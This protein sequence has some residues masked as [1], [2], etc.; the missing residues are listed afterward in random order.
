MIMRASHLMLPDRLRGIAAAV[1]ASILIAAAS[2]VVAQPNKA[3]H[4]AAR[5]EG[6][7]GA[8]QNNALQGFSQNKNQPVQIEAASLEVRDKEKKATF[9]GNVKVVQGDTT[10]RCKA[11]VVFYDSARTRRASQ[12]GTQTMKA[13]AP[14]PG[15]SS[16]IS[17]LEATGG[18]TVTQ[19]DQVA[20]GERADFDMK[21]NTV[22]LQGEGGGQPGPEPDAR[23]PAGR[24]SHDRGVLEVEGSGPVSVLIDNNG[25]GRRTGQQGRQRRK[26]RQGWIGRTGRLRRDGPKFGPQRQKFNK[27]RHKPG[28]R[29]KARRGVRL[30]R[31]TERP[32]IA[33]SLVARSRSPLSLSPGSGPV[34]RT[35]FARAEI[36]PRALEPE[37]RRA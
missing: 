2:P 37:R 27:L 33:L 16:S 36:R 28:R 21:T 4:P 13:A 23:R 29:L 9:S 18:V 19:K 12:A 8:T 30:S 31:R 25:G 35:Q 6:G 5:C 20:T 15:G 34:S 11:L 1:A 10:M 24:Q 3:M 7:A 17:R 14:G 22:I 26:R 32:D